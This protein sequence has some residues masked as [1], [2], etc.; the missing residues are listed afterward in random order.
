MEDEEL[1]GITTFG[2]T[3]TILGLTQEPIGRKG[4]SAAYSTT[5]KER[6]E[7]AVESSADIVTKLCTS[8]QTCRQYP[9]Y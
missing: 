1:A 2:E 4:T 5:V 6:R 7:T 8:W 9:E 3:Q